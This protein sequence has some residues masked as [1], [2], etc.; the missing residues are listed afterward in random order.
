M[1]VLYAAFGPEIS[2]DALLGFVP[3]NPVFAAAAILGIYA[4]KSVVF[5]IPFVPL[6]LAAGHIFTPAVAVAVNAVGAVICLTV[7]YWIGRFAG[8][9]LADK[10][11]EKYPK[12]RQVILLQQNS[13]FFFCF[14][15][16]AV[17]ILPGGVVT[18]YLG[19]TKTSF[20][21][22]ILG[23]ILGMMPAMVLTTLLETGL[24]NPS[25][26]AIWVIAALML[27]FSAG[28]SLAYRP[29]QNRIERKHALHA[30]A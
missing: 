14:F 30:A 3:D 16:R 18:M 19:A 5:V 11:V 17:G 4:V 10:L 20:F 6:Q 28:A 15:L 1:I 27:I 22:N 7:P 23:G 13:S 8:S 24:R 9:E 29:Y 2:V 25:S 12:F 26:P 21:H